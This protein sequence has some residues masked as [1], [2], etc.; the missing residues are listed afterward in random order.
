MVAVPSTTPPREQFPW[1]DLA[2]AGWRLFLD[3]A[4]LALRV[5]AVAAAMAGVGVLIVMAAC[6]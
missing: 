1:V 6:L 5:A 3:G 4:R 2:G